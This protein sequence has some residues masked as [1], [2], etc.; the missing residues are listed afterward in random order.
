MSYWYGSDQEIYSIGAALKKLN[1][2]K[3]RT[4]LDAI[5]P[6]AKSSDRITRSHKKYNLKKNET[7]PELTTKFNSELLYSQCFLS[8]KYEINLLLSA[9]EIVSYNFLEFQQNF[10]VP[11]LT[12]LIDQPYLTIKVPKKSLNTKNFLRILSQSANSSLEH[13]CNQIE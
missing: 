10:H 9:E 13:L 3:R 7:S 1:A 11:S 12:F 4:I 6:E 2:E 5:Q 8:F